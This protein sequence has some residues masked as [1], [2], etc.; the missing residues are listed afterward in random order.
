VEIA[1]ISDTHMPR[2]GRRLPESCVE[3]LRAADLI[4]HAGDLVRLSVLREL[5]RWAR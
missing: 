1:I 2:G 4:L 3:R 5:Q